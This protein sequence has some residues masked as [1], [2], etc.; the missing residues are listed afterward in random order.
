LATVTARPF[1]RMAGSVTARPMVK[2]RPIMRG[3]NPTGVPGRTKPDNPGPGSPAPALAMDHAVAPTR[4]SA[5]LTPWCEIANPRSCITVAMARRLLPAFCIGALGAA[6]CAR[7]R[8]AQAIRRRRSASRTIGCRRESDRAS[9]DRALHR[10]CR[11][12][13]EDPCQ[14]HFPCAVGLSASHDR[15]STLCAGR[16][17]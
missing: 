5:F 17:N 10:R 11:D 1:R 16:S 6:P 3:N 2:T 14:L 13:N 9:S 8:V 7:F 12:M 4:A 15:P